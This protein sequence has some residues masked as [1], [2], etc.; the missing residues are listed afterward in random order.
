MFN[1]ISNAPSSK[2]HLHC[3][4][5]KKSNAAS[6]APLMESS[7][8]PIVEIY[9]QDPLFTMAAH[10]T[11]PIIISGLGTGYLYCNTYDVAEL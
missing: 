9:Y 8:A 5:K 4:G 2:K 3:M 11:R 10:P 7:V 1:L 6:A